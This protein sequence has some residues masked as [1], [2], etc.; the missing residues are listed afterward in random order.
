MN[1]FIQIRVSKEFKQKLD[2]YAKSKGIST[3]ALIRMA[4]I[5]EIECNK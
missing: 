2:K 1:Q 3:S 5:K 4:V